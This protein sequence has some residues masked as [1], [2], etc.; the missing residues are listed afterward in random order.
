MA[1]GIATFGARREIQ[2]LAHEPWQ[3]GQR[4]FPRGRLT[5]TGSKL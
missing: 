3:T 4:P 5:S 2:L 1:I